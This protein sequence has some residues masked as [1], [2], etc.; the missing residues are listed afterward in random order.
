MNEVLEIVKMVLSLEQCA[1]IVK[2]HY[3]THLLKRVCEDFIQ[4]FLNSVSP[5]SHAILNLIKKF[6]NEY[7]LDDLPHL[8]NPP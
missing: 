6:K 3:E 4:E 2:W 7:M 8:G 1:F 5:S